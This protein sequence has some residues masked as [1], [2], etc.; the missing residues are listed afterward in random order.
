MAHDFRSLAANL[1]GAA[2]RRG[3]RL[4]FLQFAAVVLGV[5]T[6]LMGANGV[7]AEPKLR[8]TVFSAQTITGLIFEPEAVAGA[9]P[10][11]FYP[12]ARSPRYEFRRD[13]PL[14]FRD[15]ET[16]I[17]VAEVAIPRAV[18][19]V[20]LL[21]EP[22]PSVAAGGLRYRVHLLDE[23]VWSEGKGNLAIVNLSGLALSGTIDRREVNLKEG[24]NPSRQVDRSAQVVLRIPFKGVSCQAYADTIRLEAKGRALLILF[25]PYY[26]GTLELQSR[27]L[28][29]D[30]RGDRLQKT[31]RQSPP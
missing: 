18:E 23:R 10:V 26:P 29:D 12:M 3:R 28:I 24:L 16:G 2:L 15:E 1:I 9:E 30:P 4:A 5:G 14:Q 22:L 21:F 27:L 17:V 31:K 6:N 20:L 13:G 25:P 19:D 11:I 8:F 7:S